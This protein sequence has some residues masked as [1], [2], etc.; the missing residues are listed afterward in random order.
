[1]QDGALLYVEGVDE[2]GIHLLTLDPDRQ[3]LLRWTDSWPAWH[4]R[5]RAR[6]VVY[7]GRR[8]ALNPWEAT[9]T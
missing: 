8:G 4:A 1:M 5:L 7:T 2:Q 6:V 3:R 9:V